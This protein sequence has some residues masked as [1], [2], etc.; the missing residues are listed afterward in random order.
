MLYASSEPFGAD[1]RSLSY[2]APLSSLRV[3][4]GVHIVVMTIQ[5]SGCLS[6]NVCLL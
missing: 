6:S 3:E 1:S 2:S 4:L 5:P